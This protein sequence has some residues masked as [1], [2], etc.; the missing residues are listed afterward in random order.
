MAAAGGVCGEADRVK[1]EYV[2]VVGELPDHSKIQPAS[3]LRSQ[4][5]QKGPTLTKPSPTDPCHPRVSYAQETCRVG[6]SQS[7][8]VQRQ[9][10]S[11][12]LLLSCL[13]ASLILIRSSSCSVIAR[14]FKRI[15]RRLSMLSLLLTTAS[16]RPV[17]ITIPFKTSSTNVFSQLIHP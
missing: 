9:A 1:G 10:H 13:H 7:R 14:V 5:F 4:C 15:P 3:E 16:C 11:R 17:A 12:A 8:H 6:W 2:G